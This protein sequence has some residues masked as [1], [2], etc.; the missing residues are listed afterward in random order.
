MKRP[1]TLLALAAVITSPAFAAI[2]GLQGLT[3]EG[4]FELTLNVEEEQ[5]DAL[6]QVVGFID[7]VFTTQPST[8]PDAQTVTLCVISNQA[9]L[10]YDV[11]L[12]GTPLLFGTNA[13]P[14]PYLA[15]FGV[16][17]DTA[18]NNLNLSVTNAADEVTLTD[19][20][21]V[22]TGDCAAGSPGL[23]GVGVAFSPNSIPTETGTGSAT[24]TLT[25]MP[26]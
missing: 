22:S 13:T 19:Y 3:S 6:V 24:V 16:L 7:L 9:D 25:I 15:A 12:S 1:L 4:N 23:V 18:E 21:A 11:K 8:A 17:A 26:Q 5:S 10:T 14:V 20:T 2:D